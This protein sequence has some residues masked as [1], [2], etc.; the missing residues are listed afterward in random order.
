M[1][2]NDD[3]GKFPSYVLDGAPSARPRCL[4]ELRVQ[5]LCNA[6]MIKPD[7]WNKIEREEVAQRW[8]AEAREQGA[9]SE[10][11]KIVM[12]KLNFLNQLRDGDIRPAPVDGVYESDERI[13]AEVRD[14][15]LSAVKIFEDSPDKDWHPGSDQQVLD[16]V[17]PSLF[18]LVKGVSPV[19]SEA[20]MDMD[21]SQLLGHGE[22]VTDEFFR[23]ESRDRSDEAFDFNRFKACR[24]T[25][26]SKFQWLPSE[27]VI[28]D[29]GNAKFD[30]YVNNVHPVDHAHVVQVLEKI[31]SRFIPMFEKVLTHMKNPWPNL[32]EVETEWYP[33]TPNFDEEE[34]YRAT[35][36]WEETRPVIEPSLPASFPVPEGFRDRVELRG[37]R[38]QVITKLANI[39]LT[40]AKPSYGGG[41]W[42]VEGME[43]EHI[44]ASGIYYYASEN[45]TESR[46]SFRQAVQEPDYEQDDQRGVEAVYGIVDEDPLNQSK[47][48][49]LCTSG[50]CVCFPNTLQHRVEPFHLS[51]TRKPGVRKILVFF[52]VDPTRR[53]WSTRRVPPQQEAWYR[54]KKSQSGGHPE[55]P[56]T[57]EQARKYRDDL[58]RERS[59]FV[60]KHNETVF[61]RSFSLCEH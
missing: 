57:I 39:V 5:E 22:P 55:R 10:A 54:G 59:R 31:L 24:Y 16:L 52:L 30:S 34:D 1:E 35:E 36:Q 12:E 32:I 19:V 51:D 25:V 56:M 29:C 6:L 7:W 17:H 40:P 15:L 37:R 21:W 2:S 44:V 18:C 9:S 27:V 14:R 11:Y 47:G 45:I 13:V 23:D 41:A 33:P 53:V 48:Y 50:R 3:L 43:N 58:M 61:E 26:S 4:V 38:L 20:E 8:E 49:V 28:D 42:H 60:K 46:L